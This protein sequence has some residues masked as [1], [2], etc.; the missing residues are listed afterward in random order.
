MLATTRVIPSVSEDILVSMLPLLEKYN[1]KMGF[2]DSTIRLKR[3][4]VSTDNLTALMNTT[5]DPEKLVTYL[6]VLLR[7]G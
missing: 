7:Q 6:L 4:T 3:D 1:Q 2:H 5:E